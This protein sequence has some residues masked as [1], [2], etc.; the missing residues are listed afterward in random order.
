MGQDQERPLLSQ[1]IRE[2]RMT[3][4][5]RQYRA[6]VRRYL[7]Q[8]LHCSMTYMSS[9][10]GGYYLLRFPEGTVEETYAG[11]STQW[12]HETT[13]RFPDGTTLK[14]Y[15]RAPLKDTQPS[16]VDL[17]FPERL[18]DGPA[19]PGRQQTTKRL[20]NGEPQSDA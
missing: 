8:E 12:T 9:A 10:G 17:A 18:L 15:S 7:E 5:D 1:L 19:P 2:V 20:E 13:I 3:V 4:F 16:R 11:R 6:R 14:K